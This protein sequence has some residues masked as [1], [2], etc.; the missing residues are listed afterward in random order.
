MENLSVAH[1]MVW[2]VMLVIRVKVRHVGR[3]QSAMQPRA[4]DEPN[5]LTTVDE[6][7]GTGYKTWVETSTSVDGKATEEIDQ[8]GRKWAT[9]GPRDPGPPGWPT[10]PRGPTH[11]DPIPTVQGWVHPWKKTTLVREL[12]VTRFVAKSMVKAEFTWVSA[13]SGEQAGKPRTELLNVVVC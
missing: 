3:R 11:G 2:R 12:S 4:K 5:G 7:L 1:A 13:N 10:D 6:T 9:D 8:N